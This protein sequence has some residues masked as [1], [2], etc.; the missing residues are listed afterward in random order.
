MDKKIFESKTKKIINSKFFVLRIFEK[1]NK[2][3]EIGLSGNKGLFE[4]IEEE[5]AGNGHAP[6]NTGKRIASG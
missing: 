3:K 1:K 2:M 4:E 5:K 6:R